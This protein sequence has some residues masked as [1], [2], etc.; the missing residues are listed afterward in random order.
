LAVKEKE[1]TVLIADDDKYVR[2]TLNKILS[3]NG[4]KIIYEATNGSEALSQCENLR[5][6]IALLDIKMPVMSG[7]EAAKV[8]F[9][10][11]LCSCIIMLTAFNDIESIALA[12][13]SGASG[14]ITKPLSEENLIPNMEVCFKKSLDALAIS[15]SIVDIQKRSKSHE[16]VSKAKLLIMENKKC[17]EQEAFNLIRELSRRKNASMEAIA[18]GIIER[19]DK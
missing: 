17:S 1:I 2:E 19:Y 6:D 3:Q 9:E 15:G 18:L 8:I 4:Y 13:Q 14:Y 16:A 5:P 7:I 12:S 10:E 11:K